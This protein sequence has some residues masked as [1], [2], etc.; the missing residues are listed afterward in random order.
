MCVV[1]VAGRLVVMI[2]ITAL[3]CPVDIT[4]FLSALPQIPWGHHTLLVS[5]HYVFLLLHS[6]VYPLPIPCDLLISPGAGAQQQ[7][8]PAATPALAV[9]VQAQVQTAQP[10]CQASCTDIA[11]PGQYTCL[12]QVSY[13]QKESVIGQYSL[14]PEFTSD[15]AYMV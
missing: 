2:I 11:P 12:Q 4:W 13:P 10:G 5:L 15:M 6:F 8:L 3:S 7:P 1:C 14:Q 9:P